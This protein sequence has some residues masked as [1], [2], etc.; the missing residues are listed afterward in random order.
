MV[1]DPIRLAASV[2][3]GMWYEPLIRLS[4]MVHTIYA[5]LAG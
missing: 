2:F 4:R 1:A 5:K 3:G